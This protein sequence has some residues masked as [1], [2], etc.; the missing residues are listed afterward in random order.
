MCHCQG[1]EPQGQ[2]RAATRI[3]APGTVEAAAAPARLG[4][5]QLMGDPQNR[6]RLLPQAILSGPDA[7]KRIWVIGWLYAILQSRPRGLADPRGVDV[8]QG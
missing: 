3:E 7:D 5:R 2:G 8:V 4:V 6:D 1:P